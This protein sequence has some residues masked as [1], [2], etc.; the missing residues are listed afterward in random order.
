MFLKKSFMD[1]DD[2]L[3]NILKKFKE[4]KNLDKNHKFT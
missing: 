1:R 4:E 3:D 2:D